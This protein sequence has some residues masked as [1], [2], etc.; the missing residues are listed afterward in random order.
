MPLAEEGNAY[1][2]RYTGTSL[3]K[4]SQNVS[5][6]IPGGAATVSMLCTAPSSRPV[7]MQ[8]S[9]SVG[10]RWET[11]RGLVLGETCDLNRLRRG[12]LIGFL[13]CLLSARKTNESLAIVIGPESSHV[14]DQ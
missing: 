14:L 6:R 12:L 3:P 10:D 13:F 9:G 8:M 7:R 1:D 5:S 4:C 11:L 2:S